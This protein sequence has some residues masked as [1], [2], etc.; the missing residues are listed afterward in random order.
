MSGILFLSM[1]SLGQKY[2][3]HSLQEDTV[4]LRE[5]RDSLTERRDNIKQSLLDEADLDSTG[6]FASRLRKL[7]GN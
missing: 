7:F 4:A 5:E 3:L 1:R 6:V 2:R